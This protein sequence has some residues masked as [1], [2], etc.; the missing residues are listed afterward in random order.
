MPQTKVSRSA[1]SLSCV[2]FSPSGDGDSRLVPVVLVAVG[3]PAVAVL[4]KPPTPV[5]LV[6]VRLPVALPVVPPTLSP[7]TLAVGMP[8]VFASTD[9]TDEDEPPQC[10]LQKAAPTT[11]AKANTDTGPVMRSIDAR[12]PHTDRRG[13]PGQDG[14]WLTSPCLRQT[15]TRQRCQAATRAHD[16]TAPARAAFLLL[17]A[18]FRTQPDPAS[19]DAPPLEV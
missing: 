11:V 8:A 17:P 1:G 14:A 18:H 16:E 12:L 3:V 10:V 15:A 2:Q 19:R 13:N 7:V 5:T 4:P 6:P 9:S